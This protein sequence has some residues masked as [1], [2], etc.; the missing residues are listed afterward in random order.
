MKNKKFLVL[1]LFLCLAP[2]LYFSFYGCQKQEHNA[3][4]D[5]TPSL[6]TRYFDALYPSFSL[7][8]AID[9]SSTI[10]YGEI[11]GVR[12]TYQETYENLYLT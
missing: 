7:S 1:I 8:E 12:S 11:T 9:F 6:T 5:N 10:V 2:L 3:A 4:Q